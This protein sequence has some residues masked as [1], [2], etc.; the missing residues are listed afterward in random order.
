MTECHEPFSRDA[1]CSCHEPPMAITLC[2]FSNAVDRG[3][4]VYVARK[5]REAAEKAAV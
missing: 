1:L 5:A 4:D 3:F 2:S